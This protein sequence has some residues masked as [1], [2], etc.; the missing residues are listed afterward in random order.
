M[1]NYMILWYALTFGYI[2]YTCACSG[3]SSFDSSECDYCSQYSG[4]YIDL[5]SI[6]EVQNQ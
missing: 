1:C 5:L 3:S 2:L 4:Y 6:K